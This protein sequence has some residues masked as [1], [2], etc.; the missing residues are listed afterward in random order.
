MRLKARERPTCACGCGYLVSFDLL[1]DN[2]YQYYDGHN[3]GTAG[4]V[5]TLGAIHDGD[6]QAQLRKRLGVDSR[7]VSR[8]VTALTKLGYLSKERVLDSGR[9][10]I[11]LKKLN[12]QRPMTPILKKKPAI[13]EKLER[14]GF[15]SATEVTK[16]ERRI[17]VDPM[18]SGN[19]ATLIQ[20]QGVSAK[21][22]KGSKKYSAVDFFGR[23]LA[24]AYY[25][26][27]LRMFRSWMGPRL[28][29]MFL[30]RNSDP[31]E[32]IRRAFSAYLHGYYMHWS[33]CVH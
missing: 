22:A 4:Y 19:P 32:N 11:R 33:R 17:I 10:T 12:P 25:V 18:L 30:S 29:K 6:T 7:E 24:E 21:G 16:R 9:W 15:I 2:W 14:Q 3:S 5:R 23:P 28:E 20:F 26:V 1:R 13:M 27:D 8:I 31:D